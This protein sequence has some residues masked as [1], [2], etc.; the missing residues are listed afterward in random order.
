[1]NRAGTEYELFLT[2]QDRNTNNLIWNRS[3][4]KVAIFRLW[5]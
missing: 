5:L 3:R 2:E 1:M 4:I